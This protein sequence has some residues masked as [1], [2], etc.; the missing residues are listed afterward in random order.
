VLGRICP[1]PCEKSCRREGADGAVSICL[2]KRYVADVDLCSDKP[3]VPKC[4]DKKDKRVAIIGA[5]P[6][7]LSAGYYLGQLGY[8]STVFD[9]HDKAGGMLR[10]GVSRDV[11]GEDVL[12]KEI[13]LI[14][15]VGVELKLSC[16]VGKDISFDEIAKRYDAVFVATGA[17]EVEQVGFGKVEMSDGMIKVDR[18][19]Y[20]TNVEGVFAGGDVTGKRR[21]AVRAC[22][23]G[24][25]AAV[26]ID[27]YL[28]GEAV[29]GPVKPFNT[30]IGKLDDGEM[31][32]CVGQVNGEERLSPAEKGAGFSDEQAV[33][34]AGRCLHCDCRKPKKCKLREYSLQYS[35]RAGRYKGKRRKFVQV[36]VHPEI[37]FEPGKCIDCGLCVQIAKQAGEKL[38]MS[39][40]G[41]GFSV[42]V[43]TPFGRG[44]AEGLKKSA[45]KCAEVC[46]TGAIVLKGD[47]KNK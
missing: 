8:G 5:G 12:D 45:K 39:F 46:P 36:V 10:Y 31:A 33:R 1:A 29:V 23:H 42:R 15:A 24:K 44:I 30:R 35:A 14:E 3:F 18:A 34:E 19:S 11:P 22:A 32:Y 43:E 2:L 47:M 20:A 6:A 37:I 17:V 26:A 41:R 25:E 7:G 38:G 4:S 21:L 40:I 13:A 27:Q 28:R 16:Q 9:V